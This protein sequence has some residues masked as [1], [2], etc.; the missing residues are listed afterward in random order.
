[1]T[2]AAEASTLDSGLAKLGLQISSGSREKLLRYT[3]LLEKWNRTHNL[4]AVRKPAEM[5]TLHL[6]DS[7]AIV[8][9]LSTQ[10]GATLAD[11]GSGAGLPGIPIALACPAWHVTLN[12]SSEKKAAFLRQA[13]IELQLGNV[14]VHEGRAQ[15]WKPAA[16]FAVVISRAFSDLASF[17]RN[18]RH[19]VRPGGVLAAM[20]GV[21][22][23][24]ELAAVPAGCDCSRVLKL[25]VP[26]LPAER[27]LVLCRMDA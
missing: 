4:T 8:P 10:G 5:V 13:A 11:V 21:Y 18:C 26:G 15:L 14:A 1:M 17:V 2:G 12:D 3:E 6:L 20:K 7:L 9:H 24:Q 23:M 22:P 19:L 25:D 16:R 27:H